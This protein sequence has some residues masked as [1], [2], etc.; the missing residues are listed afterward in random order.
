MT[1]ILHKYNGANIQFNT[2]V[3]SIELV[4]NGTKVSD[5]DYR[6]ILTDIEKQGKLNHAEYFISDMRKE[7]I[8]SAENN[9]WVREVILPSM[10]KNG[11]KRIAFIVPNSSFIG[12]HAMAL[13][14]IAPG[15]INI[16]DSPEAAY[17]F[18]KK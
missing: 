6:V 2:D 12:V 17:E 8:V 5:A 13:K 14:A 18:F 10:F 3:K 15:A 1:N 16:V 4:W 11:V 9:K 7:T